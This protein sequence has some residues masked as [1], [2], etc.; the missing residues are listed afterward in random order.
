MLA[1]SNIVMKLS[2][3]KGRYSSSKPSQGLS[4][5][6]KSVFFLCK[7]AF[8]LKPMCSI[9]SIRLCVFPSASVG[10]QVTRV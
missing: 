3:N 4:C 10:R 5:R 2:I 9:I 1:R 8:Q 6:E 7:L